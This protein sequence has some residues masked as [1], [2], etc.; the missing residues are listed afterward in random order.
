MQGDRERCLAAGMDGYVSKP[1]R[2]ADLYALLDRE[3]A[4]DETT[5]RTCPSAPPDRRR[6]S[7]SNRRIAVRPH[8]AA[9]SML[10]INEI[11]LSVQ[12]E[13]TYAGRPCTFVRLTAC[14]LRCAWCDTRTPSPR[15]ARCRSTTWWGR[16]TAF[17]CPLVELTGGEPM[18]QKEAVPLMER[19]LA[20]RP[21][22]AARDRRPHRSRPVPHAVVRIVDVKC[23]G[24]GE[25]PK[26]H[27]PNLDRLAP[28]DE[29]KFVIADRADYEYARKVTLDHRLRRPRRRGPLLARPWGARS[30]G[31]LGMDSRGPSA[32]RLQLQLH[33]YIW[34]RRREGCRP[35][36]MTVRV[37]RRSYFSL[38]VKW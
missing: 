10:T 36:T 1:I 29:V 16:S 30:E 2:S 35:V 19:L 22:R 28:H 18:L 15:D 17:G 24:S 38:E 8:H 12:G 37:T 31:P 11:F 34:I 3:L 33:K 26:H 32:G 27:W 9:T 5:R 7:E 4:S 25:A 20:R 13:S 14:D 21:Y 23:P 6:H